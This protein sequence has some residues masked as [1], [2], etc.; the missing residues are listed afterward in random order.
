MKFRRIKLGLFPGLLLCGI[1]VAQGPIQP[2]QW[3]SAVFPKGAVKPGNKIAIEL[4]VEIPDN[5]LRLSVGIEDKDDL[6]QDLNS[7]LDAI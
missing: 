7:R 5:L 3:S 1:G 4:S 6:I 2:V